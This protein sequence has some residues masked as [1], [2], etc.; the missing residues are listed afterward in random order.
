VSCR[1]LLDIGGSAQ[2]DP[3]AVIFPLTLSGSE[4]MRRQVL[5]NRHWH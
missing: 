2:F 5:P 4:R 3:K 1:D